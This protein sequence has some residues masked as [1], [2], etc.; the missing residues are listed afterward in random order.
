MIP[1]PATTP[2]IIT[3]KGRT[4]PATV[5]GHI[6]TLKGLFYVTADAAGK[7]RKIRPAKL[8]TV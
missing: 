5:T 4:I 1:H 7:V 8:A 2:V 3:V 6:D